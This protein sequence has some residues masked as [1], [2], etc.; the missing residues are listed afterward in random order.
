MY[1]FHNNNCF[2]PLE[3]QKRKLDTVLFVLWHAP[4]SCKGRNHSFVWLFWV[5]CKLYNVHLNVYNFNQIIITS[6]FMYNTEET[7]WCL[8]NFFKVFLSQIRWLIVWSTGGIVNM[9]RE[10]YTPFEKFLSWIVGYS[11]FYPWNPKS[12]QYLFSSGFLTTCKGELK[13]LKL[14]LIF[15]KG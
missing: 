7:S 5:I 8:M 10:S 3:L 9:G 4:E 13:Q 2:P 14:V 6:S 11:F 15:L 12:D 1:I